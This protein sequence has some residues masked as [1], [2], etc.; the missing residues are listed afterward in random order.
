VGKIIL[1]KIS[2]V[3]IMISTF[4]LATAAACFAGFGLLGLHESLNQILSQNV[5]MHHYFLIAG[6]FVLPAVMWLVAQL[7]RKPV[8][9]K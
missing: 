9:L 7:S 5:T 3:Y 6:M 1:T 8:I 2:K 4:L